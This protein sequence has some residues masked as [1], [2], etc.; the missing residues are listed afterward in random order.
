MS[1]TRAPACDV[2]HEPLNKAPTGTDDK[3]IRWLRRRGSGSGGGGSG[4]GGGGGDGDGDGDG[5]GGASGN[6]V[7]RAGC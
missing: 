3:R 1:Y 6:V 7:Y 5:S 4:G 2:L